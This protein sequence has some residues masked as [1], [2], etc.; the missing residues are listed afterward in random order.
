ML[1]AACV[2]TYM[3]V[4]MQQGFT[5]VSCYC[6]ISMLMFIALYAVLLCVM[7]QPW[8]GIDTKVL[9]LLTGEVGI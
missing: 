5:K 1:T 4:Y 7:D 3:R 9:K 6:Q 2:L 8:V